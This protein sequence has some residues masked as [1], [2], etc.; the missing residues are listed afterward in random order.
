MNDGH[1]HEGGPEPNWQALL[2]V[3]HELK[4]WVDALPAWSEQS[5]EDWSGY[6]RRHA[7][8]EQ[9]LADRLRRM[10]GCTLVRSPSGSTT[11]LTLAGVEAKAR[12]G[13]AAACR[14]WRAKVQRGAL[15]VPRIPG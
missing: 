14:N 12:G 6:S 9:V 11:T 10:P 5:G 3:A 2:L 8:G 13:P 4:R 7:K 15:A 1:L